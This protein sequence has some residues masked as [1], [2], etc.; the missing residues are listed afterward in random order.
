MDETQWWQYLVGGGI[1]SG[2]IYG[3]LRL[4]RA[5]WLKDEAQRADLSGNLSSIGNMTQANAVLITTIQQL[6]SQNVALTSQNAALTEERDMYRTKYLECQGHD[7]E[8]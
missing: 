8:S 7:H 4:A 2:A 1:G 3:V 6:S 5:I